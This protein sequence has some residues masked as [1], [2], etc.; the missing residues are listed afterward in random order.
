ML[1]L[2]LLFINLDLSSDAVSFQAKLMFEIILVYLYVFKTHYIG[3]NTISRII[4]PRLI[5][6]IL[7]DL[8]SLAFRFP[9]SFEAT[10]VF[11]IIIVH[12]FIGS[13]NKIQW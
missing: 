9:F 6:G 13:T 11:Q 5:L 2:E 4:R 1:L 12:L 8:L 3:H 10:L 7:F